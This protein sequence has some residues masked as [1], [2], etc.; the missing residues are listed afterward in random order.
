M[1]TTKAL[2]VLIVEDDIVDRKLLDRLLAKS[3]LSIAEVVYADRLSAA[4]ECLRQSCFDV[5]LLDLGLPDSRGTESV[6]NIQRRAPHVPIIV[7]SGLDDEATATSAVQK[8]VQDYLIKGQVDSTLLMRSIRYALE[9][10]KAERQLQAA[11]HR[12]RTIFDNSAVAIMMVDKAER[13]VS[14]NQFTEQLLGM[15]EEQLLGRS[16]KSLYPESE[17]QRIRTLSVRQKGMQH[18][19]ETQMYRGGGDLIDVDISLSVLRD[20]D[21]QATGSIGVVRDITERRRMEQALRRSEERFRQVVENANEWIWEVDANGLYTYA[22]PIIERILGYTP[23]EVLGKKHFYDFFHPDDAAQLRTRAFSIFARKDVFTEFQTRNL[24]K[25]GR[26]VFLLRS[27]VPILDED[28]TLLGY[29]GADA[30]VTERARIHEILDR[31]QKNL[32]VIFDAAPVGMLLVDEELT[33][34]RANEAVRHLSG[35]DFREIIGQ[36]PC[37]ALGCTRY[38]AGAKCCRDADGDVPCSLRTMIE[39][40]FELGKP[41]RSLEVCPELDDHGTTRSPWLLASVEPV[42]IDSGRFV[43]VAIDDITD[44]KRAEEELKEAVEMKSQF[45]STVSHELR[46]PL[47]SMKEAVTIVLSGEAGRIKKDQAH[48]LDIAKRNINR[49]SRLIND[50]LDF[51]RLDA[52]NMTFHMQEGALD[53][54]VEDAYNTMQPFAAKRGVHLIAEIEPGLP[55]ITFD[56]D[57]IVQVV[58]NLVSNGIKFTPKGGSIRVR[59]HRR[60]EHILIQ[61]SDTGLGIPREALPRIFERFYRVRRPGKEIQGTGLGLPIVSRI[62]NSHGGR[63]DVESEPDKGTTFTVS[64]PIKQTDAPNLLPQQTDEHLEATLHE[65]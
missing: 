28:G 36:G 2:R 32:G 52:G 48:F 11:E 44:R 61:V 5:V 27:G 57:R 19:L 34:V 10:K 17:W 25:D 33:V 4:L 60:G 47:T 49:L 42:A 53:R 38:A 43:V 30:D 59:V 16:V 35:R 1:T 45:I 15:S 29:R 3:S 62:I 65:S 41:I 54:T 55:P 26:V 14:W 50:V 6:V 58:T 20:S 23:E 7:L 46:T 63:I 51:Q 37:E 13:L 8:G 64:L 39:M 18:H 22:S 21:G 56:S 40:V 31:K 24:H 9:R 12:Y